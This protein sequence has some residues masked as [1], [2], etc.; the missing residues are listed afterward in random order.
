MPC[1][2]AEFALCWHLAN[3]FWPRVIDFHRRF[4]SAGVMRLVVVSRWAAV[5]AS[6]GWLVGLSTACI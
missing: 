2:R 4:Y 1:D 6:A 5:C 3:S